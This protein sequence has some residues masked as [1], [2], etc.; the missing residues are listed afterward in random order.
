MSHM[1]SLSYLFVAILYFQAHL[2]LWCVLKGTDS[3]VH[4]Y[5]HQKKKVSTFSKLNYCA[6]SSRTTLL[7]SCSL[8]STTCSHKP[9]NITLPG[10]ERLTVMLQTKS[11]LSETRVFYT[12]NI[13][14]TQ[15]ALASDCLKTESE[16]NLQDCSKSD[17]KRLISKPD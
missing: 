14:G 9:G 11:Y 16:E 13:N 7:C 8:Q 3:L 5:I 17:Q 6:S 12:T 15:T 4:S 1:S 2:F 10:E